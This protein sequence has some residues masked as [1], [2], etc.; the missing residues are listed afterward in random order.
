MNF[1]VVEGLT[2]EQIIEVYSNVMETKGNYIATYW[3]VYCSS[4]GGY[5]KYNTFFDNGCPL[6]VGYCTGT[7]TEY[8]YNDYAYGIVA[9]T[10]GNGVTGIA[11]VAGC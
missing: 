9:K 4:N 6:R 8:W 2:D 5:T 10:C 1:D 7:T 11:Y 3:N